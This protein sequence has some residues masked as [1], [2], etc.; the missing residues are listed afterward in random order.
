[1]VID[2]RE[3]NVDWK[4]DTLKQMWTI[5]NGDDSGRL[6][7]TKD[8]YLSF[9]GTFI[10]FKGTIVQKPNCTDDEWYSFL[11][12]LKNPINKHTVTVPFENTTMTWQFYISSGEEGYIGSKHGNKWHRTV[13]ITLTAL[14]AQWL[15]GGSIR[16]ID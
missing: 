8:M 11:R 5:I 16:G 7:G 13:E 4:Q 3:F 6:Q 2:N 1:M 12:L 14:K 15:A 10:N 9:V